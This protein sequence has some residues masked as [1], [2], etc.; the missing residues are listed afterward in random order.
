MLVQLQLDYMPDCCG[1]C[2]SFNNF[3]KNIYIKVKLMLSLTCILK[4]I[5]YAH[6]IVVC[7][8]FHRA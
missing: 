5:N 4:S 8:Y 7:Y 2:T 1:T 6:A 3:C